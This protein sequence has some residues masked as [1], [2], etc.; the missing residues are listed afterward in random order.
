MAFLVAL[1]INRMEHIHKLKM[2]TNGVLDNCTIIKKTI[3]QISFSILR[4]R[5]AFFY[6]NFVISFMF[7]FDNY[8]KEIRKFWSRID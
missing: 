3:K 6:L 4:T 8:A 5:S 1:S 7:T 2:K